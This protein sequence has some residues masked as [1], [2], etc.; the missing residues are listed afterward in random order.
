VAVSLVYLAAQAGRS[1]CVSK[2]EPRHL[3]SKFALAISLFKTS[4]PTS[5][6]TRRADVS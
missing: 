1:T 6:C 5:W 3:I 4:T 2:A